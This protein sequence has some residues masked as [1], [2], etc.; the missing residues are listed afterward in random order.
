M[1]FQALATTSSGF[2]ASLGRH[3]GQVSRE[4][5]L[6][7]T[8]ELVAATD[9]P[10]SADLESGFGETPEAVAETYRLAAE[11]GLAGASIEDSTRDADHPILDIDEAAD[12][13]R[14]AAEAFHAGPAHLVLTGRAENFFHGRHDLADTIRRL[15][16]YQEA[17]ADVLY[18]PGLTQVE[19]I[20]S[21]VESVDRPVNVL[22]RP[23]A[24]TV[25]ELGALGVARISVGGAFAFA[26]LGAV[27][28]AA[29]EFF[30][31]G[32]YRYAW[33]SKIGKSAMDNALK[34]Q[35]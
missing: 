20:R 28:D 2:A 34:A 15:Q 11:T 27:A 32:T 33:R 6:E 26:A 12:R 24:P 21:V 23:T 1:G 5:A 13:V 4:E 35:A 18:A 17:G 7:H 9:L 10:V 19:D 14:A 30:E 31:L 3:D 16:A 8:R 22:A 29:R 25:T